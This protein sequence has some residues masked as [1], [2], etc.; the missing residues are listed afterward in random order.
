MDWGYGG[1][2]NRRDKAG[3]KGREY[4]ENWNWGTFQRQ[5]KL[6]EQRKLPGIYK[7]ILV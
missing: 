1:N 6:L 2:G 4:S 7:V 5:C 3:G